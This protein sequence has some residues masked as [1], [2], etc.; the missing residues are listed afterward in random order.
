MLHV[1]DQKYSKNITIVKMYCNLFNLNTF[2]S[3]IYLWGKAE[4]SALHG[5]SE[6]ILICWFLIIN[7]KNTYAA[8]YFRIFQLKISKELHLFQI[9]LFSVM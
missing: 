2:W 3:A 4:F 5:P 1:F 9:E 7:V 6:I 8:D